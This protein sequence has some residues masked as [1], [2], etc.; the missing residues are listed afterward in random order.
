MT[1]LSHKGDPMTF[2]RRF[3]RA[4]A[5]CSAIS[6][7]TTLLLIFLPRVYGPVQGFE[8]RMAVVDHP[9]YALRSWV[10]LF[11][12]L[13]VLVAA[14]GVAAARRR[15]AGGAAAVGFLGFLL[16]AFTEA[17]Q[18]ALTL[19][20]FDRW[21]AAY[22]TMDETARALL[23]A[24]IATY[25]ALWDAMYFLLL[26]GF[27]FGNALLGAAM[28]KGRGLTRLVAL[29]LFGAALLTAF[30]FS[31]EVQGPVLP[32]PLGFWVYPALQPLGRLLIGVWLWRVE[33]DAAAD[34]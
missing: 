19:A 33:G 21:R 2:S 6:A 12:P 23:P 32:Q 3:Y 14:L 34:A 15:I 17:A 18:Q 8:A 26:I 4:A 10:Y 5:V 9:A 11:H 30:N 25:D 1:S 7:V 24:Q 22:S 31:G 29:F 20:T 27:F 13:L 16:W 28:W